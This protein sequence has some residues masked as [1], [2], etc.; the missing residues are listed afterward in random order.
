MLFIKTLHYICNVNLINMER[1]Y[2][3][4][5]RKGN[6]K[7]AESEKM[8]FAGQYFLLPEE[9][10]SPKKAFVAEMAELCMVSE[11]TVRCWIAGAYRPDPL[12][13]KLI[14]QRL[15]IEPEKLFPQ[16]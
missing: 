2:K 3:K 8:T 15:G 14:S 7:V 12:K 4:R 10:Y 11:S 5:G 6:V 1:I 16:K 13:S 9:N